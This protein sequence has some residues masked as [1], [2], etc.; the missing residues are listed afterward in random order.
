MITKGRTNKEQIHCPALSLGTGNLPG[1]FI[2][3]AWFPGLENLGFKKSGCLCLRCTLERCRKWRDPTVWQSVNM[4]KLPDFVSQTSLEKSPCWIFVE[5]WHETQF[6]IRPELRTKEGVYGTDVSQLRWRK[7]LAERSLDKSTSNL[8]LRSLTWNLKNDVFN[9]Y[10]FFWGIHF[11]GQMLVFV[12]YI[13]VS[14]NLAALPP[15]FQGGATVKEKHTETAWVNKFV[16][17]LQISESIR[18][19]KTFVCGVAFVDS[20]WPWRVGLSNCH[21]VMLK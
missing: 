15:N 18:L 3:L 8:H 5:A 19:L 12:V 14:I 1:I 7:G 17:L 16:K 2:F 6:C 13:S 10:D 4:T 9:K 11:Q 20:W 21:G